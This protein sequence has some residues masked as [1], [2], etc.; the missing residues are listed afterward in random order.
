MMLDSLEGHDEPNSA[1]ARPDPGIGH[2]IP[3]EISKAER[4]KKI[5]DEPY[6]LVSMLFTCPLDT[7]HS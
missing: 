3:W 5:E 7:I 6:V 2:E 4:R 1:T